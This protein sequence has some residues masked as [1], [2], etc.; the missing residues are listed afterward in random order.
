[1]K[2]YI[3]FLALLPVV[4][5]AKNVEAQQY[6]ITP[7]SYFNVSD[8]CSNGIDTLSIFIQNQG[9]DTIL[10]NDT[11]YISY[12]VNGGTIYYDTLFLTSDWAPGDSLSVNFDTLVDLTNTGSYDFSVTA[13]YSGDTISGNDTLQFT[14]HTFGYPAT[15]I[16]SD[17]TICAGNTVTLTVT[18]GSEYLWNTGDTTAVISVLPADTTTYIVATSDTNGCQTTDTVVVNVNPIPSI[19]FNVSDTS[20][21]CQGTNVNIVASGGSSY[22]WNTGDSTATISVLPTDTAFYVVTVS[23]NGCYASDS[24]LINFIAPS[25]TLMSDTFVCDGSNIT[26]YADNASSY[27]WSSG[28]SSSTTTVMPLV[29]TEYYVTI[30]ETSGCVFFDSVFVDVHP[31]PTITTDWSDTTICSGTVVTVIA[32]GADTYLWDNDATY[33]TTTSNI[34][35]LS[36]LTTT[37]FTVYGTTSG[38]TDSATV[39]VNVLQSPDLNLEEEYEIT[40]DNI[41][42]LGVTGGYAS[43]NWSNGETDETILIIGDSLGVGTYTYWVNATASNGCFS[44]DTTT[45]IVLEGVG[46]KDNTI[47]DQIKIYP[48]PSSGIIFIET[49]KDNLTYTIMNIYGEVLLVHTNR[50]NKTQLN[51]SK[52]PKGT[53]FMQIQYNQRIVT[54]QK[55]ILY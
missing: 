4:F 39:N 25:Y 16:T 45:I 29:S 3:L 54:T 51:L 35:Q 43:Y 49:P 1:M 48:N 34:A 50:S 32:N 9:T 30:T 42:I 11:V 5:F 22:F 12:S 55:I 19:S 2:N 36:P 13:Y 37:V 18:G 15:T 17:T 46:F 24:V 7:V 23:S 38:C 40:E 52:L 21:A 31:V 14:I 28:D 10:A 41:L 8:N 33:D 44:A 53:Y 27:V 47:K 6:D 20:N 26:L